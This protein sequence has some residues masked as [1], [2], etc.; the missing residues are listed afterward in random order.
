MGSKNKFSNNY[1]T[2]DI[3][4]KVFGARNP[5]ISSMEEKREN[6][7][8]N[9]NNL[10]DLYANVKIDRHKIKM[11]VLD[12]SI[13]GMGILISDGFS[14]FKEG[15]ELT[16][17]TLE[18]GG[19]VIA[20]DITGK[21]AY[22][23]PGVPSRAGIEFS[24]QD[25]PIEAYTKLRNV[26]DK[27]IRVIKG[28]DN[29]FDL[30]SEIKRWSRGFGD[31]LMVNKNKAIPAEFFYLRPDDNNMVLRIVRI[32]ELRLPFEPQAGKS[33]TFYL[34]KGINVMIFT[35]KVVN[36]IKNILETTWPTEVSYISR[37]SMARYLI[38]GDEPLTASLV[39]P[40]NSK[41]FPVVIWDISIEGMGAE[42]LE[43]EIPVID[44]MNLPDIKINLP[45]G[46]VT[47]K[48]II[49][50]VRTENMLQKTQ[51]GIEFIG[52]P[53]IFRDKILEFILDKNLLSDEMLKGKT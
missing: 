30:F 38:T 14:Y 35:V 48:G 29:I 3:I 46:D 43:E 25:T 28:N 39:H 45:K 33:Y 1:K 41:K 40:I 17:E 23:G 18:K 5:I 20:A 13:G 12:I 21:I 7:R 49:R 22:L 4:A 15:K 11:P 16:I 44:G 50:S 10:H 6:R 47:G 9:T 36:I 53:D 52:N 27:S 42:I 26:N 24:P 19:N 37:R 34:F 2:N 31:M 51:L 32:S 8:R